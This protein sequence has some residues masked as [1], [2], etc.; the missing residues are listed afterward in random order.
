MRF[1]H[2]TNGLALSV[3]EFAAIFVFCLALTKQTYYH[4]KRRGKPRPKVDCMKKARAYDELATSLSVVSS[5]A[6]CVS[7]GGNLFA[8]PP[9]KTEKAVKQTTYNA[10]T[11]KERAPSCQRKQAGV[12]RSSLRCPVC[13][14]RQAAWI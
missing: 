4:A 8:P 6:I 3:E 9:S 10:S 5:A 7:L 1:V 13:L 11:S 2:P 14:A 12:V